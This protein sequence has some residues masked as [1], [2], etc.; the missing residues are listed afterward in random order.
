MARVQTQL[1]PLSRSGLFKSA[2][3]ALCA[4]ALTASAVA[5]TAAKPDE[6]L[7]DFGRRAV[8]ELNDTALSKSQRERRFR[9]L[10]NEAVDVRTIS[11]FI[12]GRSW[13]G[14]SSEDRDGFVE[15]FEELAMRRLL[16]MFTRR[17]EEN[18][19]RS[20]D[21]VDIRRSKERSDHVFVYTEVVRSNGAPANLIWRLTE[22]DQRYKIIDVTVEGVSMAL[23][24]RHEYGSAVKR[25]GSVAA[26]VKELREKLQ[27]S[28]GAPVADGAP[29]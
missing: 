12:L 27:L 13:R 26:L 15:I 1:R 3:I 8:A 19:D 23:T 6:F 22:K 28:A 7:V 29:N 20:F 11:R 4:V 17:S 10:L 9:E 14:A 5:A 25:L 18:R 16:P 2:T 24:L 21:V